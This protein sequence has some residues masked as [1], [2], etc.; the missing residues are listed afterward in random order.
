[1]S[2]PPRGPR[3][4]PVAGDYEFGCVLIH[5]IRCS[6]SCVFCRAGEKLL[7]A[8]LTR[9]AEHRLHRDTLGVLGK[10]LRNLNVSGNEPLR[11]SRIAAYLRWIRPRFEKI[12]L[13]D[14]GNLLEDEGFAR[15][16]AS[17]GVDAFVIP[18]Y[19]SRTGIHDAC[20]NNPGAFKRVTRGIRNLLI[21]MG[22]GQRLELT[23]IV[24]RQN[25][26]DLPDLARLV[27]DDLGLG[28][29]TVNS[30]MA[31]AEAVGRFFPDF[32]PG[33][34]KV[35]S[36]VMGMSAVEGLFL[37]TRYIPPCIFQEGELEALAGSRIEI[38][39]VHFDYRLAD[40][41]ENRERLE[42]SAR[43]RRQVEHEGCPEC[44]L[45]DEGLCSGVLEI[46]RDA[47][48]GYPFH[49]VPRRI[50]ERIRPVI[51]QLRVNE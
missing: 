12:T 14:P 20:V 23:T 45:R 10:G 13:L 32:D 29:L 4:L 38:F 49:P 1:M 30:P 25:A 17:T 2:T 47:N 43:Y 28:D 51:R 31:T 6:N 35:R 18:L 40:S 19:G 16:I 48:S 15:E 41:D 26:D 37:H 5:D 21:H 42:Y 9:E 36:A 46:H 22:K 24:L 33:F 27:R 8:D 7:P 39:N 50:L 3:L 44:S 11:Y 34:G